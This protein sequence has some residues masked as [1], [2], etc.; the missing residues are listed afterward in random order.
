MHM[1]RRR[2]GKRRHSNGKA[3]GVGSAI[4]LT[5]AV[6]QPFIGQY[7]LIDEAIAKGGVPDNML[8]KVVENVKGNWPLIVAGIAIP[9]VAKKFLGN[10]TIMKMG[11]T[12]VMAV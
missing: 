11:R 5:I 7:N 9:L 4:G 2:Y 12:R 1:A 6:A 10:K 8:N 3:I